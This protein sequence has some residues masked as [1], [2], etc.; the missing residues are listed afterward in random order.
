[1]GPRL[2]FDGWGAAAALLLRLVDELRLKVSV[3]KVPETGQQ[4]TLVNVVK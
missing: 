4:G 1:M 3:R 2:V